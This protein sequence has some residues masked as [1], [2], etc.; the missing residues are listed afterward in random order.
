M[1][2]P[3]LCT[4]GRKDAYD[5]LIKRFVSTVRDAFGGCFN[6]RVPKEMASRSR[7]L[8]ALELVNVSFRLCFK[9][10]A[11]RLVLRICPCDA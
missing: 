11:P 9:L 6:H 4:A 1:L 3:S 10:H 8:A 7:K 2:Q 5:E